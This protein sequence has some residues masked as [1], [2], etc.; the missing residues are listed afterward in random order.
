[1][2]ILLYLPL[3][4]KIWN[5]LSSE[6]TYVLIDSSIEDPVHFLKVAC[7]LWASDYYVQIIRS[8]EREEEAL[9]LFD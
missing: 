2:P 7:T 1:M 5:T 6:W 3:S 9:E 8:D 4:I